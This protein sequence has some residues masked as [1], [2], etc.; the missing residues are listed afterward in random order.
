MKKFLKSKKFKILGYFLFT[1]FCAVVLALSIRGLPG[2]PN[3]SDLN[4]LVWK[5]NGPLE[6]SPERG[7]F[8]LTYALVE[9]HK[10]SFAPA[11]ASF[12]APD[13]GY[14]HGKYVSL[15]AP[16][17]S[18]II[19]PGYIIGKIL[20]Y[21]QVGS[22]AVIALFALLNVFLIRA[23]VVRLGM[24]P[25][26]GLIAG[27]TFLF[28]TPAFPYAVTLYQ[29]HISTFLILLAIYLLIRFNS[30]WSLVAIWILCG[31]SV[32]VDYPNF[33][34]M[35]PIGIAAFGK[36]F[37]VRNE[38]NRISVKVSLPRLV[39]VISIIIP[40]VFFFWFNFASYG[41][42]LQLAGTVDRSLVVNANG[43]P[44]LESTA[45]LKRLK[46][47]GQ[48]AILPQKSALGSF[49]NR[50]IMQGF[51][52]HFLSPDRGMLIYTPVMFFGFAGLFFALRR[53]LPY[54]WLF[55]AIIGFNV[56]LYSMWDDPYGGWAFGSRYLIPTYAILSIFIAY[57]L[58]RIARYNLLLLLFFAVFSYSVGVNTLG[59]ITSNRNPPQVEAQALAKESGKDQPYT[60]IRNFNI[61]NVD[62][63]KSVVF[64]TVAGN[65]V[66]AW[67][68]YT[69]LTSFIVIVSAVLIMSLRVIS[70]G[71]KNER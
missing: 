68:Y 21:S 52:I 57:I 39:S 65:Y 25:L 13:V 38:G 36:S 61:L 5:D 50:L 19:I 63:S 26:V 51:Y 41:N 29:H 69:Y 59:A 58:K 34:M 66:T 32:S 23:V 30:F 64:E 6:L 42:P 70:K 37:L 46:A 31:L 27:L 14:F 44:Q 24:H 48:P 71:K 11:L 62:I 15:F 47:S 43:T 67:S 7:R 53:K 35:L 17:V 18:F 22:F 20:G 60:Y 28:A 45:V 55:V 12:A 8:A 40:M 1:L 2:N 56:L 33:F 54:M 4:R 9:T 16:G 3:I 49:N 10:F